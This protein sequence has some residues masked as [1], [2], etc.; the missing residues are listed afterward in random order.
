[1]ATFAEQMKSQYE[2]LLSN[3]AGLRSVN[4]D[5]QQVQYGELERQYEYWCK[6]VAREQGK[7]PVAGRINL[8]GF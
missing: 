7:R 1:M 3:A 4:I 5:G 6:K 2:T 8:G